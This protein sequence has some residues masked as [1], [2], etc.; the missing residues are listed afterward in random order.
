MR[1]AL[2]QRCLGSADQGRCLL[3]SFL[4]L[5]LLGDLPRW[6]TKGESLQVPK[7]P[8]GF[9]NTSTLTGCQRKSP[10]TTK[11]RRGVSPVIPTGRRDPC[12][13]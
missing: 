10:P 7:A 2:D 13:D 4:Y 8:G 11:P 3:G 9:A 1:E 5:E 12:S 6:A